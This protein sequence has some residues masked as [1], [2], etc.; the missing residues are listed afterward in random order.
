MAQDRVIGN[1]N[2]YVFEDNRWRYLGT[3]AVYFKEDYVMVPLNQN[4][5]PDL[6]HSKGIYQVNFFGNE[7]TFKSDWGNGNVGEFYLKKIGAGIYHGYPYLR[8][9]RLSEN[10]WILVE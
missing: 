4:N 1:W 5:S 3:F 9:Q 8:G 6:I 7:W 2:Q 10:L